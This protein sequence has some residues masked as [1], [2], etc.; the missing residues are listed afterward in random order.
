M[1][2]NRNGLCLPLSQCPSLNEIA[3]KRRM[4]IAERI[5]LRR[6]RCGYIGSSPLVCCAKS[7]ADEQ[8]LRDD[9]SHFQADDLPNDCGKIQMNHHTMMELIVGGDMAR[10]YDSPWLALLRYERC[11]F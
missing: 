7:L 1:P 5:F 8:E 6:S 2:S 9:G 11:K 4:T 10:I 3:T